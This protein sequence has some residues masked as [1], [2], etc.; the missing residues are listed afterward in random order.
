MMQ[1]QPALFPVSL[2]GPLRYAPHRGDFGERQPTEEFQVD[3]F[4]QLR[5]DLGELVQ[6]VA[7]LDERIL[8]RDALGVERAQ[9]RDLEQPA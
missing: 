3:D 1:V 5:F 8:I 2:N 4:G 9:R 6:R 7:D